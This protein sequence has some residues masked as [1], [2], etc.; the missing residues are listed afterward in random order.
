MSCLYNCDLLGWNKQS[1][2]D[3]SITTL[4][5]SEVILL[6]VHSLQ[7]KHLIDRCSEAIVKQPTLAEFF[8]QQFLDH[9]SLKSSQFEHAFFVL[10]SEPSVTLYTW[11][12]NTPI[13]FHQETFP[14]KMKKV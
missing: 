10:I 2:N 8:L 9:I 12:K 6:I 3:H 11:K 14:S 4:E 7:T 5:I 1:D 13:G